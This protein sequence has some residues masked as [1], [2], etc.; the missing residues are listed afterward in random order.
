M[1]GRNQNK[2]NY[3]RNACLALLV[4]LVV[5]CWQNLKASGEAP[6]LWE[7]IGY[8]QG[9]LYRK[10]L[11]THMPGVTGE[12]EDVGGFKQ[13]KEFFGELLFGVL[14]IQSYAMDLTEYDTQVES[15]LTYEMLLAREGAD[16][17]YR[18]GELID[19][20]NV[21]EELKEDEGKDGEALA[22]KETEED[23]Q[24]EHDN[25]DKKGDEKGEAEEKEEAGEKEEA[26]TKEASGLPLNPATE[27][28]VYISREKLNDFD[29][30][31]QHFY[32][33][34]KTTTIDGSL[35]NAQELLAKD[36]KLTTP[37]EQ[38]QILIHHTHSQ[39]GY[40][41][42]NGDPSTSIVAVGEYLTELLRGYGFHVIH[43]TGAYDVLDHQNAYSYAGPAVEQILAENPSIEVVIDMHRDGIKEGRLVTEVNG[44][45]TA[46]I[47]F[48]NGLSR[49]AANGNLDYLYNPYLQDNLAFSLQMKLAAEEYY[50]GFTR[51]N[52]LKGYRY[53]LHYVPKSML[54]EVG[55][56]TNTLEEAKNAMEPLADLLHKVLAP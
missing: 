4:L 10:V 31:I 53:N 13:L 7:M 32:V 24:K 39:E 6:A 34:D 54:V 42:S 55:A 19:D 9:D 51:A 17:Q 43:D 21:I 12:S 50:P 27:Q 49:T 48:F 38:P 35:L 40:A 33:V 11:N 41:D 1:H 36:M 26:D 20:G 22:K 44:K 3:I 14:P 8:F 5:V 18:D 28:A 45:Q 56:Q 37:S 2:G 15:E 30:L 46:K 29:Y 47:M 16:E 23:G 25:Q 52:Y